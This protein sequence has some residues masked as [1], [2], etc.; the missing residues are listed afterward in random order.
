MNT[1][2]IP[3]SDKPRVVIVGLGFGGLR[4]ARKLINKNF[5]VVLIDK[6]NY[7]QF[8]PLF[9]QVAMSGIEPSSISFPIRK[10][11]QRAKN[12]YF[13]KAEVISVDSETQQLITKEGQ[14]KFD[15]LLLAMGAGNNFFGNKSMEANAYT[16]KTTAE[17]LNLRNSILQL[18]E[19]NI[20]K[21]K[22]EQIL[23]IAVIGGGPTGVELSGALGEMHKTVL[24]HDYPDLDFNQMKVYLLEG[25]DRVLS[26]FDVKSSERAAK[27]LKKLGVEVVTSVR[28]EKYENQIIYLT[29]GETLKCG[30]A[31]WA[32]GI[33]ANKIEGLAENSYLPNGRLKCNGYLQ[34]EQYKNIYAIGDQ[35]NVEEAAWPKGHPQV[36]QPAIQQGLLFAKNLISQQKNKDIET[37]KYRD[38]GN[39][40]TIGRNLAVVEI[41]KFKIGGFIA[42]FIWM[43][44]H[45]MSIVGV[46][47]RLFI[48]IN[49][50]WSY[51]TYDQSLRLIIKPEAKTNEV[52]SE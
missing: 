18:L 25:S 21:P 23:N 6:N 20:S 42:W 33:K 34:V 22:A 43:A 41:G 17:S 46:K 1:L 10:V 29:N 13:R 35:A 51:I 15:H 27:G 4:A 52:S 19:T 49:W 50:V 7:F 2:N 38:L 26:N 47:N 28:A 11:F 12:V 36:A 45:L 9:Y 48:F 24:P 8:Q 32:A 14:I 40:A 31:I 3:E 16:M 44:V 5:Q 30:M 39:M 37:F